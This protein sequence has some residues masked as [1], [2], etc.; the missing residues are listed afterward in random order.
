MTDA[1]Q[2]DDAERPHRR[3]RWLAD[4]DCDLDDFVALVERDDRPR[5]LPARRRASSTDVLVYDSDAAA[6]GVAGPD[7]RA[8]CRPSWSR[9]LT[10]GPGIVVFA[11]AFPDTAVVDRATAAFDALI[12]DAAGAP[13]GA[14]GDHFAKPGRQRPGLERAGEAGRCATRRRSP[15]TTPTTSSPWSRGLARPGYQVTSQVNVVNPGGAGADRAPRLPPRLPGRTTQ[16]ARLPGARAPAVPGADAAGRGRAL[17]HAG[18]DRPDACTCRTRSSTLP[19]YLAWRLPEFRDVLRGATTSS[20]RWPR[21]TRRSSTRRCSTAPAPTARPTSSG[22]PTCCRS[23]RR[24]AGR[25]RRSTASRVVHGGL[26]GAAGAQARRGAG[27]RPGATSIAASRGG[28]PVPDQP[29]PA[30]SRSGSRR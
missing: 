27:R 19:G 8:R 2:A 5:R 23:P 21:A 28:L 10:D 15:T 3:R 12:A 24:S 9:A 4:D 14:A 22:W 1:E 29:R 7:G 6:D 13:G 30:T 20:C 11:G 16:A 25:W 26:P 17:R 18:R